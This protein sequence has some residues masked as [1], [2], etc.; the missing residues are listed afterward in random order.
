[1]GTIADI[2]IIEEVE[3]RPAPAPFPHV[4][5][6]WLRNAKVFTDFLCEEIHCA[7]K[8]QTFFP[9]WG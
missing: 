3:L 2:T 4:F 1:M 5:Q 7:V 6:L 8:L 9:S